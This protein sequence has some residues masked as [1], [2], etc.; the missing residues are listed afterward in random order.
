MRNLHI[1]L[2]EWIVGVAFIMVVITTFAQVIFRYVINFSLPW[3]GE[4]SRY[5]FVW[6]IYSGMIISLIRGEHAVV[7]VVIDRL[8]GKP[9]KILATIVDI[10]VFALFVSLLIGG[11]KVMSMS[12]GQSTSGLGIPKM[13]VYGALPF[14]AFLMLIELVCRI[15]ERFTDS[16]RELK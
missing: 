3:T 10:L 12:I 14:G 2:S 5:C 8:K 1:K 16:Y 7:S 11:I 6:L 4:L 9:K 15:Y 13:I